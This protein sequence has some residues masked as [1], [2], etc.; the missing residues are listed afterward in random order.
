MASQ[1]D[2]LVTEDESND[3]VCLLKRVCCS[4]DE[5]MLLSNCIAI[6]NEKLLY[7]ICSIVNM[8]Q[9]GKSS[10]DSC[11]FP[12]TCAELGSDFR[13]TKQMPKDSET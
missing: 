4:V 13:K 9:I 8:K 1:H 6:Y 10:Q 5:I 11:E 3:M 12:S 2:G 7:T